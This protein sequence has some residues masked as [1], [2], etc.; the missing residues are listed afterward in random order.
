MKPDI[1]I[2]FMSGYAEEQLRNDIDIEDMHFIPKPFSVQQIN[3]KVSEV[4]GLRR[5]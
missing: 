4:L 3:A 1:P 2:L 5:S